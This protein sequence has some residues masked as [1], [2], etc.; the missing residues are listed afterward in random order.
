LVG[1]HE[2]F[3]VAPAEFDTKNHSAT[4]QKGGVAMDS[5]ERSGPP[6]IQF[7]T[8]THLGSEEEV[9]PATDKVRGRMVLLLFAFTLFLSATLLFVV[10]PMVAKMTL[11]LVGGSPAVWSTCMVF[12]QAAL[13]GGYAYAHATT[14]WLGVRRQAILHAGLFLLP[15]VLLPFGIPEDA[16]RSLA[17]GENPTGWLLG[18]LMA[19][20]GLPFFMVATSAPLLQRWFAT[21]GHPAASDPY[22]LYGASNLGSLLALLAYPFVMEP[23]LRVDQQSAAWAAG[24]GLLAALVLACA[25]VVIWTKDDGD[26]A[27]NPPAT[28]LVRDRLRINQCLCWIILAFIPSSLM[29]G[30]TTHVSTDMVSIPLWWIIPLALYL[31]SF[32]LTFARRPP[33]PHA[34]MIRALPMAAVLLTLAMT[35]SFGM[36][37]L[38]IPIHL[39]TFFLAAMVC[40]GE[41]ARHRPDRLNLT[42]FY[43]AISFGGVLGGIFNALVAP[44]TFDRVAEYPLALVLACLILP[45]TRP[46]AGGLWRRALDVAIPIGIGLSLWGL[47]HLID[48]PSASSR[49]EMLAKLLFGLAA[50]ACYTLKERP[51]RFA[52]GI[53]AVLLAGGTYVGDLGRVLY[54][55][56]NYFGV[57]RVTR[58]ATGEYHRLIHG[59]TVHGVQSLDPGRRHEP[60]SYYCRTGP[61]G[62]VFD[63]FRKRPAVAVV[64]LGVGTLASYAEPGQRWVFYEIDPAVERVA[65]RSDYFTFLHDSRADSTRVIL[66][67][68]RL[69]LRDAPEHG[70][71]LIV[72]DAFSSDAIPTHLLTREALR[73]YR[74]KLSEGGIIAFH[75]S[76]RYFDLAP[77][78]GALARDFE[79]RCLVRRDLDVSPEDVG[80]GKAASTWA[81]MAAREEDLGGLLE[82]SRWQS[83]QFDSGEVV[84]TDDFSNVL[85]HFVVPGPSWSSGE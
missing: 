26:R 39:L 45:V 9:Q 48:A 72:L 25:V 17:P 75:I 77:V 40:H 73:L 51:V 2:E 23:T 63:K 41:L 79:I 81:V 80:R 53:G 82:D 24:Y 52:L 59:Q 7:D 35:I 55:H 83:P 60:L 22:F 61:I 76:N 36:Q 31:L 85:A 70:Y 33:L 38:F 30:V 21:T 50:F 10:Q 20:V 12:F 5:P 19:V 8:R 46:G 43:L 49:R 3:V 68:A 1:D 67:D 4:P 11:S 54:E 69:R 15:L 62:Q 44:I 28:A 58:T 32:I 78:L 6:G 13:L 14:T 84:W 56:R 65:R 16:A 42:T 71:G 66:G 64:G 74:S 37:P 18:L 34:W 29:L 27:A 57:L 47:F